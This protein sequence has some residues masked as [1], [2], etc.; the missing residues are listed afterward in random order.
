MRKPQVVSFQTSKPTNDR[1]FQLHPERS[2]SNVTLL[3]FNCFTPAT[4]NYLIKFEQRSFTMQKH[5][6]VKAISAENTQS[7]RKCLLSLI[8]DTHFLETKK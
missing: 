8:Q 2:L 7:E 5:T 3:H 4:T 1:I 6:N